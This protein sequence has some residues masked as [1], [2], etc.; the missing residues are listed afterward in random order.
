[1]HEEQCRIQQQQF[2][3]RQKQHKLSIFD[4]FRKS[5]TQPP[6]SPYTKEEWAEQEKLYYFND[7]YEL[8]MLSKIYEEKKKKFE[9]EYQEF[10]K[11]EDMENKI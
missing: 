3:E 8:S 1:M 7:K 11:T 5:I 10:K 9:E 6:P 4:Y 2:Y